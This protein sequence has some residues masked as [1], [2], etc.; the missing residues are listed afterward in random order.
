MRCTITE[1]TW[2]S[3][4]DHLLKVM[5]SGGGLDVHGNLWLF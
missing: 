2:T 1:H 4:E 5:K 3:F